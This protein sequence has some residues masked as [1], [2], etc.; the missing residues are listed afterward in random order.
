MTTGVCTNLPSKCSKA[1]QRAALP[2]DHDNARCPECGAALLRSS[3]PGSS[4]GNTAASMRRNLWI[5]V[6][7]AL[8]AL[9]AA[10]LGW[11]SWQQRQAAA[12]DPAV[13]IAAATK[14]QPAASRTLASPTP[15]AGGAQSGLLRLHGSNTI[16][17]ALAPALL[18]AFLAAEG[19]DRVERVAG[20]APEESRLVARRSQGGDAL[21]V[22]LH[23]HGSATAF[24][25]L[26][27]G[28]ADIGLS[29]RPVK[30][31]EAQALSPLGDLAA[32]GSEYV[33][34]LDGVAV[35][36]HPTNP[37][38]Q[39]DSTQ[40]RAL[41]AGQINDW[42]EVG[43]PTG[44]V[45]RLARDDKSGTFDTFQSLVMGKLKLAE[46]TRR[47]ED[48]AAL[49]D[50]VAADPQAIGFIGLPYVR[51]AKAVAVADGGAG[52]L[53]PTRL[54]IATEDY[55]LARRLFLYVPQQASA[56]ARRFADFAVSDAGQQ[57]AEK[58]GFVGQ[59]PEA[60]GVELGSDVPADYRSLTYG[61]R[62]LS[63]NL[64]F[65]PGSM[66][67]D[68]KGKQDLKRIV[69]R[70]ETRVARKQGQVLL[71]GFADNQGGDSCGNQRLS[72][73]RADA[74]TRELATYGIPIAVT[75][76]FGAAAPVAANDNEAGRQ[77]N[78]RVEVWVTDKAVRAPAPN[79]CLPERRR[80]GS[81]AAAEP[82][83]P[84]ALR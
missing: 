18:E 44:P 23:A 39:L 84:P 79:P 47:F 20:G 62:R 11:R 55:A 83:A 36:V 71:L 26:G 22:E 65:R 37:I 16:G 41:F 15:P 73:E 67:L 40:I 1:A 48:S 52:A 32:E 69:A 8:L 28:K 38:R 24:S 54:T 29:S 61:A 42:K 58:I 63:V 76:G 4:A 10:W 12:A 74:V 51:Q 68:N 53:R 46:G 82:P 80:T 45:H 75:H 19:Y 27:S 14:V 60:V 31:D 66:E 35:I 81:T 77:R 7:V 50:A 56:L 34:A 57:I 5:L 78:R 21:Q 33:V 25:S 72:R 64:R 70:L 2:A 30:P 13:Q 49:S 43:G 3:L 6:G 17:A 59:L 9:A